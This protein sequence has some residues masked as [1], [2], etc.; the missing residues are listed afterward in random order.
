MSTV[1]TLYSICFDYIKNHTEELVSLEGVPYKPTIEH[2]LKHVFT[3]AD[4]P[5]NK[6]ILTVVPQAHAKALRTAHLAWTRIML[7]SLT[8]SVHPRLMTLSRDFPHFI[9]HLKMGATDIC[10]NDIH[11]LATMTNLLVLDLSDNQNITDRTVSYITTLS[12][13]RLV[14][15]KELYFNNVKGIT[16]KSLKFIGKL[17]ALQK[18]Y[19]TGTHVTESVAKTYLSSNGYTL[20]TKPR[21]PYFTERLSRTNFK[22]HQFIEKCSC[23]YPIPTHRK[24]H[25]HAVNYY[26]SK[27][28]VLLDFWRS[29]TIIPVKRN[30][31]STKASPPPPRYAKRPKVGDFLAMIQHELESDESD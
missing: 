3:S 15:L 2:I 24:M 1:P 29:E 5:L 12:L 30:H 19:L 13:R 17:D 9:T 22:M 10:D 28:A 31:V 20:Y 27:D 26:S 4:V 23:E 6:S 18:I 11:L 7:Q 14:H 21:I 8:C 16:D 25:D